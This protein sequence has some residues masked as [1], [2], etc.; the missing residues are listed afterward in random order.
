MIDSLI[1]YGLTE[2]EARIYMLCLEYSALQ[3]STIASK[4]GINRVTCYDTLQW[5]CKKWLVA[6][7][8]RNKVKRCVATSPETLLDAFGHRFE[9]FKSI[10]P[11][12]ISLS[13]KFGIKPKIKWF[14]GLEWMKA[15]YEDTLTSSEPI[16]AYVWN[17]VAHPDLM[18]YFKNEYVPRRIQKK[19]F[20][21]VLL[22]NSL[23]N[24]Q[25]HSSDKKNYRKSA[26]LKEWSWDIQCEINI[27][28]PNKIMIAMYDK[29]DMCGLQIESATVYETMKTIFNNIRPSLDTK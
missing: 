14:E 26:F 17:H 21:Q 6:E 3:P 11:D 8:I 1:Q 24:D 20:A 13:G 16:L 27:Y 10:V 7:S 5:L 2:K 28:G 19:I 25:Y 12:L 15:L 29:S 4:L 23:A 18:L 22:S 9:K